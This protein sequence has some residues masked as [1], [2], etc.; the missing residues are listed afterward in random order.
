MTLK[1]LLTP[2]LIIFPFSAVSKDDVINQLVDVLDRRYHL[3]DPSLAKQAVIAREGL[4]TTGVGKGV[5]LPH[6]KFPFTD[7]VLIAA[8]IA[9]AGID[10]T[11]ID[12]QAVQI[13]VLLLTPEKEPGKHLKLLSKFSRML[14]NAECRKAILAAGSAARIA[15]QFYQFDP[16]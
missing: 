4:M 10:F 6:G 15:E 3:T 9:P 14:N 11:A 16:D 5:A 13:F 1:E 7:D 2:D 12:G 8:G